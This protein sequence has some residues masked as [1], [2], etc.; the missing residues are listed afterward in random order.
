[1]RCY[2]EIPENNQLKNKKV[3]GKGLDALIT[4]GKTEN[5]LDERVIVGIHKITP[6]PQQPRKLFLEKGIEELSISIA[7]KGIIQP[8]VVR[9][10]LDKFEIIAGERRW[11]AAQK[12]GLKDIPIIVKDVSDNDLLELALIENIQREDLNPI[13]EASAYE[14][15]AVKLNMTHY[16]IARKVGKDRTTISNLIRLLKLPEDAKDALISE[17][18]SQGHAR[19]LL[20]INDESKISKLL[21]II[22]SRRLSVR[23]TEDLVNKTNNPIVEKNQEQ[24]K[25][26]LNMKFYT[27]Q[28]KKHLGANVRISPNKGKGKIEIDYFSNEDLSRLIKIMLQ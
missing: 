22:I 23:K 12:A 17:K 28:L 5:D 1:M 6:N 16:E 13:E 18:I 10:S 9:K 26:D 2:Q 21:A 7:E 3:L 19:A 25:I 24:N 8:I 4:G 27:D 20:S 14:T 11:R 15:L